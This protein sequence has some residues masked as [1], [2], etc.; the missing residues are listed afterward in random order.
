MIE[1]Q[2]K[3]ILLYGATGYTGQLTAELAARKQSNLVIAGRDSAAVSELADS[4]GLPWDAFEL[5]DVDNI[6][7]RIKKFSVILHLAGPYRDTAPLMRKASL[8]AGVDYVDITGELDVYSDHLSYQKDVTAAGVC[9]LTGA[10]FDV[11]PSDCLAAYLK[12]Q[13]PDANQLNLFFLGGAGMSRGTMASGLNMIGGGTPIRRNG[14][15]I[16]KM[17]P[18]SA[19]LTLAGKS[20]T[21]VASAW[22][23]LVTAGFSTGIDNITVYFDLRTS[24]I[25]TGWLAPVKIGYWEL[26]R[27]KPFYAG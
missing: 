11:T 17:Q 9:L 21:F 27:L 1:N 5:T 3:P 7:S 24:L 23:D 6:A 22:G 26:A 25:G 14:Q 15:I 16:K 19:K 12:Q 8:K 10:G 13:M 20:Q 4:L 18:P 2:T